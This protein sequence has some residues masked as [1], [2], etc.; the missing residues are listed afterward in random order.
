M[1]SAAGLHFKTYLLI[2]LMVIFGPL[3]NV[4]LGKG[5][6]QIGASGTGTAV[7][8]LGLVPRILTSGTIWLGIGSLLTFFVAYMLVLS[9]AD[10]SYVQPASA[11]AYG[12]VA[13]L[14][15]FIL[16]EVVT[17]MRWIGVILICLGV[18]LV[19]YTPPRT[20]DHS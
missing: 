15:H 3:G 5:M 10:Y 4:L 2:F 19:G 20:T 9:W 18:L 1:K 12:M 13:L 11:A 7:A 8:A 6:K 17:P 14:A 16:R